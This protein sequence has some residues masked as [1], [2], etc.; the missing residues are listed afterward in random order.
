MFISLHSKSEG[1]E[2]TMIVILTYVQIQGETLWKLQ[3]V[4]IIQ[5]DRRI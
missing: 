5:K 1:L 4:I 3:M 2:C